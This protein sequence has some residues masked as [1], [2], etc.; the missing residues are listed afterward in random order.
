[1]M[2]MYRIVEQRWTKEAALDELK[3]G[4]YGFHSAW[5]NIPDYIKKADI[6]RIRALV[7]ERTRRAAPRT[8]PE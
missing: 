2:A 4:G 7:N 3:R 5:R 1:M 6:E 8:C